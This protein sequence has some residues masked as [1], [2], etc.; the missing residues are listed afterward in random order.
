MNLGNEIRNTSTS[1]ALT[2]S[3]WGS[4]IMYA[5][6]TPTLHNTRKH[7]TTILSNGSKLAEIEIKIE[8]TKWDVTLISNEVEVK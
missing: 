1:L 8:N 4:I 6:L 5:S 2:N 3:Q 7:K